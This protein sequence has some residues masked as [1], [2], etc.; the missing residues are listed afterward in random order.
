[1][2]KHNLL[3]EQTMPQIARVRKGRPDRFSK[4]CRVWSPRAAGS[5]PRHKQVGQAS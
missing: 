4:T 2:G 3:H 1:V 5:D